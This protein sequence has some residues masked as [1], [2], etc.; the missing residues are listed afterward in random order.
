LMPANQLGRAAKFHQGEYAPLP[1]SRPSGVAHEGAVLR[2]DADGRSLE[3]IERGLGNPQKLDFD[4]GF[5]LIHR[6]SSIEAADDP[7]G[8]KRQRPYDQWTFEELAADLG[9]AMAARS[10]AAQEELARRGESVKVGMLKW[11]E[12]GDLSKRQRTWALWTLGRVGK[13]DVEIEAWFAAQPVKAKDTNTRAQCLRII[14]YRIHEFGF[15]TQVPPGVI[16]ALNDAEPQV[17]LQAVAALHLCRKSQHAA[18][19]A[20][21]VAVEK[22]VEVL[23]LAC[24]ALADI[25]DEAALQRMRA[26]TRPGVQAALARVMAIKKGK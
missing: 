13:D 3:V 11:L 24:R 7:D 19:L 17:R 2:C 20:D 18:A 15:T 14:A 9:A 23:A 21:L 26:D 12:R 1:F 22:D 25:A 4:D 5:H 10:V 8:E 6:E 16:A